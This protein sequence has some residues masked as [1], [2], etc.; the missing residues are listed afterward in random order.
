MCVS[1]RRKSRFYVIA[2]HAPLFPT[3]KN[4][5]ISRLQANPGLSM[6]AS[7]LIAGHAPF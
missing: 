4:P 6:A 5:L 7:E 1:R 2:R 3:G